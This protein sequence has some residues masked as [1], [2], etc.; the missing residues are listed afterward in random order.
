MKAGLSNINA[1][2]N[3]CFHTSSMWTEEGNVFKSHAQGLT[4][5]SGIQGSLQPRGGL[6]HPLRGG[7]SMSSSLRRFHGTLCNAMP[8]SVA[9]GVRL[10][11]LPRLCPQL[12]FPIVAQ[13]YCLTLGRPEA[14]PGL[15]EAEERWVCYQFVFVEFVFRSLWERVAGEGIGADRWVVPPPHLKATASELCWTTAKCI[16]LTRALKTIE[17]KEPM[18]AASVCVLWKGHARRRF[19]EP[20]IHTELLFHALKMRTGFEAPEAQPTSSTGVQAPDVQLERLS[21]D[22]ARHPAIG[23]GRELAGK[24]VGACS[25]EQRSSTQHPS[26]ERI[27]LRCTLRASATSTDIAVHLLR[28]LEVSI[29]DKLRGSLQRTMED[30]QE[31]ATERNKMTDESDHGILQKDTSSS[32]TAA[33]TIHYSSRPSTFSGACIHPR[34]IPPFSRSSTSDREYCIVPHHGPHPR[35]VENSII[36][37]RDQAPMT[38]QESL[39]QRSHA[40]SVACSPSAATAPAPPTPLR[41]GMVKSSKDRLEQQMGLRDQQI[42]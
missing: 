27:P 22:L 13:P 11:V 31:C 36:K 25:Y 24:A 26:N 21:S 20:S 34:E 35:R 4:S 18:L 9:P 30:M 17:V 12:L 1:S 2:G 38:V 42:S 15:K 37:Q 3:S 10:G 6:S 19:G 7:L 14:N 41:A 32:G 28:V 5:F 33:N 16:Q 23:T 39:L 29:V 8:R 40:E